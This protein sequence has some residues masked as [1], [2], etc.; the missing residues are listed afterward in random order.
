MYTYI[1]LCVHMCV[2]F[3]CLCPFVFCLS[4]VNWENPLDMGKEFKNG[5]YNDLHD[6]V[7]TYCPTFWNFYMLPHQAR[8]DTFLYCVQKIL[9]LLVSHACLL[10]LEFTTVWNETVV[11]RF[12]TVSRFT[13]VCVN[14]LSLVS[15]RDTIPNRELSG[16]KNERHGEIWKV[17]IRCYGER[18]RERSWAWTQ[19][20]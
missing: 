20:C 17:K 16:V 11:S 18:E 9:T 13:C 1:S 2:V 12:T 3:H 14:L 15:P 10:Q 8:P 6:H 19:E 4:G 7:L 5:K